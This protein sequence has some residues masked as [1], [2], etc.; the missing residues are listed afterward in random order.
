MRLRLHNRH[1]VSFPPPLP[2]APP[3][4]SPRHRHGQR[5]RRL[6]G[7]RAGHPSAAGSAPGRGGA[8][9]PEGVE[10]E[11]AAEG[12]QSGDG[13]SEGE[14]SA[15]TAEEVGGDERGGEGGGAVRGGEGAAVLAQQVRLRLDLHRDRSLD[16]VQVR[17]AGAQ[18][19]PA[20]HSSLGADVPA[21]GL[22]VSKI[23]TGFCSRGETD[24][25]PPLSLSCSPFSGCFQFGTSLV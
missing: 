15:A 2:P 16:P 19:V 20:G 17:R 5:L 4:A 13:D 22:I 8:T 12:G 23:H 10:E 3:P 14:G 25:S 6:R 24:L 11:E 21:Q 7:W 9:V 1:R 18:P